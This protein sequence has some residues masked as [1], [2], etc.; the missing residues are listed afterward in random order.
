[1]TRDP[2]FD[3]QPGDEMLSA[4]GELRG[5]VRRDGESLLCQDGAMRYRI[6]LK[7]WMAWCEK[8]GAKPLAKRKAEGK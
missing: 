1:V 4:T 6:T 5:V 3:P 2:R 8:N 7:R